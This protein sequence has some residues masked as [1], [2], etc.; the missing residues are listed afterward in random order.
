MERPRIDMAGV[1][2]TFL[3]EAIVDWLRGAADER[4]A[5]TTSHE[6]RNAHGLGP[7]RDTVRY[8]ADLSRLEAG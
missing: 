4:T 5:F 7:Y 6:R 2:A 1:H 3:A 8:A